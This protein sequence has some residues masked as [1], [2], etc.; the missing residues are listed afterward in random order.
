MTKKPTETLPVTTSDT[1][2]ILPTRHDSIDFLPA[3]KAA[4]EAATDAIRKIHCVI[5]N[6]IPDDIQIS[7]SKSIY[8]ISNALSG[9]SRILGETER[10]AR[11]RRH[12]VGEVREDF[13]RQVRASL[14][15]D[16]E[17]CRRLLEVVEQVGNQMLLV[18]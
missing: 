12:L 13:I 18:D 10:S 14:V 7:D 15:E 3:Q 4:V 17:L 11:E 16:P 5:Q 6:F 9:I 2:P 1:T 8:N